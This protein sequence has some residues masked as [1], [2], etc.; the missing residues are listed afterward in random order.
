MVLM[1]CCQMV[2]SAV[3]KDEQQCLKVFLSG[4]KDVQPNRKVYYSVLKGGQL[5]WKVYLTDPKDVILKISVMNLKTNLMKY[6]IH[7]A[8]PV[9]MHQT[10]SPTMLN[11]RALRLKIS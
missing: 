3:L 6:V 11:L 8:E 2:C 9:L 5:C 1:Q 4:R 7:R 10:G